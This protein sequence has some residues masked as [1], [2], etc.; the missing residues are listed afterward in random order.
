MEMPYN[1][2]AWSSGRRVPREPTG[3]FEDTPLEH[4]GS[5]DLL[6]AESVLRELPAARPVSVRRAQRLVLDPD[7]P[8]SETLEQIA[9]LLALRWPSK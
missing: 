1:L 3:P 9:R 7:Y 5:D 4:D 2:N 8:S 6:T